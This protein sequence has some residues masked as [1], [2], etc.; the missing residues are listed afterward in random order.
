ML[1]APGIDSQ[2][3]VNKICWIYGR[4][5]SPREIDVSS[6]VCRAIIQLF[7]RSFLLFQ[8]PG[9]GNPLNQDHQEEKG[10]HVILGKP[11]TNLFLVVPP[12]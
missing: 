9:I 3:N 8:I 7:S 1:Q 6:L 4:F 5:N 11:Q 2:Y 12:L 10:D